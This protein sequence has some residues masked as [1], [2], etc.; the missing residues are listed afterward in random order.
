MIPT[1]R[2]MTTKFILF[3]IKQFLAFYLLDVVCV[4][5]ELARERDVVALDQQVQDITWFGEETKRR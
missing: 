2:V 3:F 1:G 4:V 5:E